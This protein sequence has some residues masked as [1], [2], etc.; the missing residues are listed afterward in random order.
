MFLDPIDVLRLD[1]VHRA[2]LKQQF[3]MTCGV[4]HSRKKQ[5]RAAHS[6]RATRLNERRCPIV[7]ARSANPLD[8]PSPD[9]APRHIALTNWRCTQAGPVTTNPSGN[10]PTIVVDPTGFDAAATRVPQERDAREKFRSPEDKNR[11]D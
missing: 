2:D 4:Q 3:R 1:D 9:C 11:E 6:R 5:R 8:M 7:T 10:R